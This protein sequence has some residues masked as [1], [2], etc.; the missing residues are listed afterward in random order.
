MQCRPIAAILT[1]VAIGIS[2]S[3]DPEIA[4][5][6]YLKSGDE[7]LSQNKVKDAIVQYK[8]ALTQDPQS[9][10]ARARLA[11]AYVQDGEMELA[12]REY[13]RAAT[14]LPKDVQAQLKAGQ[15][16]LL[17]GQFNDARTRAERALE[18]DPKNAEA[19]ILRGNALVG[20]KGLDRSIEEIHE[21]INLDPGNAPGYFS[22]G[23]IERAA[24]HTG[25]AEDA[26]K[27]AIEAD[28]A[29]VS[30]HLALANFYWAMRLMPETGQALQ[31]A[32]TLA[33]QH[34]LVNRMVALFAMATGKPADAE[35]P[36][37]NLAE[38]S[39]GPDPKLVLADY[40]LATGREK[41]ALPLL[42]EL[43]GYKALRSAVEMSLA[44]HDVRERRPQEAFGRVNELLKREPDNASGLTLKGRLFAA[45]GKLD[46]AITT[47]RGA[48][49]ANPRSAEPR[50]ALGR[51]YL[52]RNEPE[53][54][55][56]AFKEA[57]RLN[58]R[59][60][61]AEQELSRPELARAHPENAVQSTGKGLRNA[62]PNPDAE[63]EHVRG[64]LAKRDYRQAK[65]EIEALLT[66]YPD[67]TA[68]LI[69]AGIVTGLTGDPDRGSRLLSNALGLY[70][71]SLEALGALVSL[72]LSRKDPAT[73]IARVEGRLKTT[74]NSAGLLLLAARIHESTGDLKRSEQALRRI[75]EVDAANL[76]AYE[77]LAR[78]Y[79]SQK[80]LDE[81]LKECE[82]LST[83]QPPSVQLHTLAGI[84]LEAQHKAAEAREHYEAALTIDPKALVAAHKLAWIYAEA[85]E[86][87]DRALQLARTATLGLP[88]S[89]PIQ[90]TLGWI[91]YKKR[92]AA[93]AIPVFQKSVELDPNNPV[94]SFHVGLAHAK[95]GD[96]LKARLALEQALTL[97]RD[98]KGADQA[99]QLLASFKG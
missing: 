8:K 36:L 91:Y 22:L 53:Q 38:L 11:N 63:L 1:L 73:A 67:H 6:E 44:R 93:L 83:R 43:A 4:K 45:E 76:P 50:F 80:R 81:A 32:Y 86:N 49:T 19:Q 85:G 27:K 31:Q 72:D 97:A 17:P 59:V 64:L 61:A 77:R 51:A 46:E 68:V 42:H 62:R 96:S 52:T 39:K 9:G 56:E 34:P 7:F 14:L 2:C 12:A 28:P 95:A 71:G 94:Y 75:I 99:K 69:Q 16:L 90:D 98:F 55:I 65:G 30:G 15:L 37:K 20:L 47:L 5:R 66:Q 3:R 54:A 78:Q 40:Y 74:P 84:L 58:P 23:A 21:A 18:L 29:S 25:E 35:P 92:L 89:A 10:E 70:D 24:G 57:L 60:V 13:V 82:E 41:D 48:V 87:L 79:I 33:P 26:F 88:G